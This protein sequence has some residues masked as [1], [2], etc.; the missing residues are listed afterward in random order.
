MS[1]K[2]IDR[3]PIDCTI[4]VDRSRVKGK[5]VV[6]TGGANGIGAEYVKA[7]AEAGAYVVIGDLDETRAAKLAA[8]YPGNVWFSKCN[9]TSWEEQLELFESAIRKS[10]T[11]R[12]D[13][14]VANAG[15]S[16]PDPV[17]LDDSSEEKPQKPDLKILDVNFTGVMYTIRLALHYFRKQYNA[18]VNEGVEASKDELDTCLVLQGSLAGFIDQPGSP[19]YNGS[20]FGLRGV[21]RSLRRTVLQHGT[22]INYIAPWYIKTDIISDSVSERLV[23]KG[24]QYAEIEDAAESLMRIACDTSVCGRALAV[25]PRVW[26]P[27][28]YLDVDHDDYRGDDMFV[29]WQELVLRASHRLTG[30][31]VNE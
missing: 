20:K 31:P 3:G 19:Q 11:H 27:Q 25:V 23:S 18:A 21:M 22:R 26:A 15:I 14:V 10:P 12:I 2:Y 24:V 16:G 13:I 17:F 28:G 1:T 7:M 5:T 6:I 30:P 8:S 29:E 9:V 4:A